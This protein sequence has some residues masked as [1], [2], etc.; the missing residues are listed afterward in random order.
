MGQRTILV[1]GC[2]NT[3]MQPTLQPGH[4]ANFKEAI[5]KYAPGGVGTIVVQT[6]EHRWENF[7]EISQNVNVRGGSNAVLP[8]FVCTCMCVYAYAYIC[9]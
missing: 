9:I 5:E 4:Y 3:Q 2:S 7:L 8:V 1:H 6:G